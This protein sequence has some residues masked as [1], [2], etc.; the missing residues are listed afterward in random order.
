VKNEK[1]KIT[2]SKL[3]RYGY[4]ERRKGENKKKNKSCK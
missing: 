4:E 3:E 1:S 2:S